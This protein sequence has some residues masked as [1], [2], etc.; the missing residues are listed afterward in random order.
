MIDTS[1]TNIT[2]IFKGEKI[3]IKME[4]IE[5][6]CEKECETTIKKKVNTKLNETKLNSLKSNIMSGDII[7]N[8]DEQNNDNY[9]SAI[10]LGVDYKSKKSPRQ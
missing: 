9:C 2:D 5:A 1:Q 3:C 8:N 6:S 10:E 4:E 7:L